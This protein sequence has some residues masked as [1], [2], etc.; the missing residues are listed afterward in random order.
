[1]PR[2][3]PRGRGNGTPTN[4]VVVSCGPIP[5]GL[6]SPLALSTA[7]GDLCVKAWS[8]TGTSMT[9]QPGVCAWASVWSVPNPRIIDNDKIAQ[10]V[11]MAVIGRQRKPATGRLG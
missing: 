11:L 7:G 6:F 10:Q 3:F 8:P 5:L 9:K 2:W 4:G 1:M